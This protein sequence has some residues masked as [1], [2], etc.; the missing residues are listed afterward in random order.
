MT[1]IGYEF[2]LNLGPDG[3]SEEITPA[4][5]AIDMITIAVWLAIGLVLLGVPLMM[6]GLG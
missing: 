2:E 4:E 1:S 5:M 6:A 3:I